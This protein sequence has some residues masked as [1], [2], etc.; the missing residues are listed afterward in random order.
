MAVKTAGTASAKREVP[1][2]KAKKAV[3]VQKSNC[4]L[5]FVSSAT[6]CL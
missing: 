6:V 4:F 5:R 3:S 2:K 1:V